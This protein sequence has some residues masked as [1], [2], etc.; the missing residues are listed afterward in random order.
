MERGRIDHG[1][2]QRRA[3]VHA[4]LR[5]HSEII[6][7]VTAAGDPI[8]VGVHVVGILLTMA[9]HGVVLGHMNVHGS[10]HRSVLVTL[11]VVWADAVPHVVTPIAVVRVDEV[12]G[13]VH[14]LGATVRLLKQLCELPPREIYVFVTIGGVLEDEIWS[15][16]LRPGL[17]HISSELERGVDE[18]VWERPAKRSMSVVLS[19]GRSEPDDRG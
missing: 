18:R 3:G 8:G 17:S 1:A 6:G 16:V 4:L 5:L 2:V 12:G 11:V 15:L 10:I 19:Q 13:R 7:R 14:D 9:V